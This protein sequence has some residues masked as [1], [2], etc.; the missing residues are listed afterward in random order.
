M[1]KSKEVKTQEKLTKKL[2][3]AL[4]E[5]K[6]ISDSNLQ[7]AAYSQ[8]RQARN[9]LS[10]FPKDTEDMLN[11]GLR[12]ISKAIREGS[13]Q[14]VPPDTALPVL[15]II[16]FVLI[17]LLVGIITMM[18]GTWPWNQESPLTKESE[19]FIICIL[20]GGFGGTTAGFQVVIGSSRI[21]SVHKFYLVGKTRYYMVRPIYG[22]ILGAVTYLAIIAGL[23]FVSG[24]VDL[25]IPYAPAV[26]CF[27]AGYNETL[28]MKII[29]KVSGALLGQ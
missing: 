2:D 25:S 15:R 24:K 29:N 16:L 23:F 19:I 4:G 13:F 18:F 20:S 22:M 21:A 26:A 27:L 17:V 10:E 6:N 12:I 5:A 14:P 1:F 8:L 28:A 9:S 11:E 7:D 3:K